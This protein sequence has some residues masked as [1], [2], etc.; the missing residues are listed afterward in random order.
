MWSILIRFV[1]RAEGLQ[2]PGVG[3]RCLPLAFSFSSEEENKVEFGG[4]FF[5]ALLEGVN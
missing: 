2:A 3:S 5:L 4:V 1:K